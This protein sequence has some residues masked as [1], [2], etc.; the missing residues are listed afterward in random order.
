MIIKEQHGTLPGRQTNVT[1][2]SV[3]TQENKG[4]AELP[5]KDRNY[6]SR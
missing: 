2:L 5:V 6:I 4:S 3:H 1:F